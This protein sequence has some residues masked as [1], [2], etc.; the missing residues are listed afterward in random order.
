MSASAPSIRPR[1]TGYPILRAALTAAVTMAAALVLSD[2]PAPASESE[3]PHE[4]NGTAQ[5]EMAE[6]IVERVLES[7]AAAESYTIEF[8]QRSY[9]ALADTVSISSARLVLVKPSFLSVSYDD[10]GR[11]VSNGESLRVYVPATEQFFVSRIG[12]AGV[13]LDPAAILSNYK[14]DP[15]VPIMERSGEQDVVTIALR[16]RERFAEP[17]RIDVTIDTAAWIVVA[18]TAHSTAGDWSSYVLESTN[19]EAPV[20]PGEFVLARP[21]GAQ[22]LTGSPYDIDQLR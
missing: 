2:L 17:A 5:S 21:D 22:L 14:P 11:I 20:A 8:I 18:L 1:A 9:W 6:M 10:G 12:S 13:V 7:Y 3:V 19:F 4:Q 16:P 15:H